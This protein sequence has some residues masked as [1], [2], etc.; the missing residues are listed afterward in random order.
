MSEPNAGK[1]LKKEDGSFKDPENALP[2]T[3][4]GLNI[5]DAINMVHLP[6][7]VLKRL[8]IKYYDTHKKVSQEF[9]TLSGKEDWEGLWFLAHKIK[10][11]SANLGAHALKDITHKLESACKKQDKDKLDIPLIKKLVPKVIREFD[12]VMDSLERIAKGDF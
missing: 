3:L 4:P 9:K 12:R 6:K 11:G 7:P 10:G 8:M 5:D 2:P 1:P